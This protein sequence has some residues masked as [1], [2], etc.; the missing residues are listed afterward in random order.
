MT[1]SKEIIMTLQDIPF[2]IPIGTYRC[3]ILYLL[4]NETQKD[5]HI[6]S[7]LEKIEPDM[8]DYYDKG[9]FDRASGSGSNKYKLYFV[10]CDINVTSEYIADPTRNLR[11]DAGC[12]A[13]DISFFND[14]FAQVPNGK[15]YY[16]LCKEHTKGI[17][18]LM[19]L[20]QGPFYVKTYIDEESK[21]LQVINNE[22]YLQKQ[23]KELSQKYFGVDLCVFKEHVGNSYLVW[24]DEVFK[25]FHIKGNKNPNGVLVDVIYRSNVFRSFKLGITDKQQGDCLVADYVWDIPSG[26]RS[27]FIPLEDFPTLNTISIYSENG[28]P[29]YQTKECCFCTGITTRIGVSEKAISVT[30]KDKEGN[31]R[32]L[33]PINKYTHSG[34]FIGTISDNQRMYFAENE[35]SHTIK[36][37]ADSREFIF[38]DGSKSKEEKTENKRNAKEKVIDILNR[39][40]EVCYICDPYFNENDFIEFV[41]PLQSLNVKIRIINSK[42]DV[43]NAKLANL[44][45]FIEKYNNVLGYKDYIECRVLR[46]SESRLHDRFIVADN[47]VWYMG[48]SFSEFGGR[49]CL[50]AKL[51]ESAALCVKTCVE[52]WWKSNDITMPIS[53]V[54]NAKEKK[55]TSLR[56]KIAESL[57][58]V[59]NYIKKS[60]D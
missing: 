21:A 16:T 14:T 18:R 5:W 1:E 7:V 44:R 36:E 15:S 47:Q 56:N 34:S 32:I 31:E 55:I 45:V 30:F 39:A 52:E 3:R 23:L 54:E 40:S 49:A 37:L 33:D 57:K 41:T 11:L 25:D 38:F 42:A 58:W 35:R 26:A 9:Q 46:G 48:S 20:R 10:L 2:S 43:E 4:E 28:M 59:A 19:P 51:S 27:V 50:L 22:S 60:Y 17:G 53:D 29:L 13:F 8:Q 6:F 12:G 24:H